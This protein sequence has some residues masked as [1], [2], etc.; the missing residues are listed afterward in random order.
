MS[1]ARPGVLV[2]LGEVVGTSV[3]EVLCEDSSGQQNRSRLLQGGKLSPQVKRGHG[4][5]ER[6]G[7]IRTL[8]CFH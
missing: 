5:A 4:C 6:M 2:V 3:P 7:D 1:G 8:P